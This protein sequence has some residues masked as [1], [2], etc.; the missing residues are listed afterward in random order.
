LDGVELPELVPVEY[1][2]ELVA[3]VSRERVHLISSRMRTLPVGDPELRFVAYMCAYCGEVLN[4]RLPG[5]MT[6]EVA[7]EWARAA[8]ISASQ[9]ATLGDR[10]DAEAAEVLNV[11]LDQVSAARCAAA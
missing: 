1:R 4:G 11:P 9:L 6:S 7:E 10:S 8:L 5:P 2:G 3:L